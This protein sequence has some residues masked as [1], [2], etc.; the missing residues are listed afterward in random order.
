MIMIPEVYNYCIFREYIVRRIL[1]RYLLLLLPA[2]FFAPPLPPPTFLFSLSYLLFSVFFPSSL[3][4][5]PGSGAA[6]N[7]ANHA[8]RSE[9][10]IWTSFVAHI[11]KS[12][13]GWKL[14]T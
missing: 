8:R 9:A 14:V 5:P 10:R 11:Y 6:G 1:G 2:M 12:T 3:F 4:P 7:S 13:I